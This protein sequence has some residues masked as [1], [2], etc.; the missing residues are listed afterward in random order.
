MA[1]L[2]NL[3]SRQEIPEGRKGTKATLEQMAKLAKEASHDVQ[4]ISWWRT[5]VSDLPSK[6]YKGEAKRIFDLVKK[7]VRYVRDPVHLELLQDPRSVLFRDGSADCDEA[8]TTVAAA[9]L[10]LGHQ[11]AFRVVGADPTRPDEF[12]HVYAMIGIEDI[13]QEGG[14][15]WFSADTTQRSSYLGWNPPKDRIS[16]TKDFVIA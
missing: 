7:Y 3:F 10:A 1:F 15:A 2:S 13:T 9:A 4:W 14:I 12:S 6:D 5:Q 11:A 16:I 8:A